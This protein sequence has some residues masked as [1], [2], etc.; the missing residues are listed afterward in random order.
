MI[1]ED[2]KAAPHIPCEENHDEHSLDVAQLGEGVGD[3]LRQALM[4]ATK[5]RFE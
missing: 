1:G 3:L 4:G 2:L 5:D